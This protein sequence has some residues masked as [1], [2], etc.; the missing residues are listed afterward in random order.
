[1]D[2]EKQEI[3]ECIEIGEEGEGEE[4]DIAHDYF[5]AQNKKPQRNVKLLMIYMLVAIANVLILLWIL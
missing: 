3:F 2:V 1:M 4:E 5:K